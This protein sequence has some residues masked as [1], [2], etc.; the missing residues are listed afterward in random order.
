MKG[1]GGMAEPLLQAFTQ[2]LEENRLSLD[3]EYMRK[4]LHTLAQAL[5]ELEVAAMTGADRHERTDERQVYRNGYRKRTWRTHAGEVSLHIPKLRRGT[6]YP[7]FIAPET[8]HALR[9]AA[10]QVFADGAQ[11]DA[12][13]RLLGQLGFEAHSS[14]IVELSQCLDD[15]VQEVRD[16][17]LTDEYDEIQLDVLDVRVERNGRMVERKLALAVGETA[18]GTRKLL[19]H[20]VVAR[21]DEV[22]WSDFL[23]D[24]ERRG[25]RS[26]QRVM[27]D[28]YSAQ[29]AAQT[30][31]MRAFNLSSALNVLSFADY[32]ADTR[33][34]LPYAA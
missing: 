20:E 15:L 32:Y 17:P 7:N 9:Q 5:M 29:W 26:V 18:V 4:A 19:A 13:E 30:V 16:L 2:Y 1:M 21:T 8:E 12:I 23:R 25:V 28:V 31:F 33:L 22:F 3:P 11:P 24:L 34:Y 10:I 14:E 27:T 6:Y